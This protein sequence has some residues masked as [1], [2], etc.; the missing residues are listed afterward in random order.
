MSHITVPDN[1]WT[2][3]ISLLLLG[4]I[5]NGKKGVISTLIKINMYS[6]EL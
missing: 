1:S 6:K 5:P 4:E 3:K 2:N